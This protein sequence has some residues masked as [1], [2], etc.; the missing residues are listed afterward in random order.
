MNFTDLGLSEKTVKAINESGMSAPTTVQ[1]DVIPSVLSGKDVFT[2]AP[3]GCGKTCSYVLPLIDIISAKKAKNILIVTAGPQQSVV[4]S[5]RFA[6]FNKYHEISESTITESQENID[7]EANVVIASPNLL[8][9]LLDEE[10]IDLSQTDILVVD[11]INLIKKMHQLD[12]LKKVLAVLP[13][14]KQNIIYTNRRSK[15]TQEILD[16]ILQTPEEIK[17]D[18]DK[19]LEALHN[20]DN[21]SETADKKTE[22]MPVKEI[23]RTPK[24]NKKKQ[25]KNE[26]SRDAQAMELVKKYHTFGRNTPAFLLTEVKLA[27]DNQ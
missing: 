26:D 7:D 15:E 11:D 18:K 3:S 23:V 24:E 12:N 8:A 27:D 4:V 17:I 16:R 25:V 9:D 1:A 10:K 20:E 13:A 19:E 22:A 6:V 2:I 5:D 21:T 14:D